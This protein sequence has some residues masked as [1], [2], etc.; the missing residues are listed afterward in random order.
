[1]ADLIE[2]TLRLLLAGLSLLVLKQ[3]WDYLS[4]PLK[5]FD[6][7]FLAKFTNLW[8]LFD[9]KARRCD[10][11]QNKLHQKYGTAV[12]MG[13]NMISLSDPDLIKV[14]YTHK[15]RWKKSKMCQSSRSRL[16]FALMSYN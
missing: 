16:V 8:R 4:S 14:V 7:P 3:V 15:P 6:G 12:R 13:P 5:S 1:M 10:I 9:V 2:F 11:T